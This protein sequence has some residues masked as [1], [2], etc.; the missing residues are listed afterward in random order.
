MKKVS[1]VAEISVELMIDSECSVGRRNQIPK[2]YYD[3]DTLQRKSY[4]GNGHI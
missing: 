3:V 4:G 2:T 1:V